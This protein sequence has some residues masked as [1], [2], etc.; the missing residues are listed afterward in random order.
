MPAS[1]KAD[2]GAADVGFE[3]ATGVAP[4]VLVTG[5]TWGVVTG[6]CAVPVVGPVGTETGGGTE[7]PPVPVGV[8]VPVDTTPPP[9]TPV[10]E[11]VPVVGTVS[12]V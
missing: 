7:P 2:V 8:V 4:P 3:A 9:V 6:G 10:P 11:P 5:A 12:G 1:Q